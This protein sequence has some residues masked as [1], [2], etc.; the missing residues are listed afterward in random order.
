[1]NRWIGGARNVIR[2]EKNLLARTEIQVPGVSEVI[3]GRV[4]Q[5]LSLLE[6]R[7][8]K[9]Y[10]EVLG[11]CQEELIRKKSLHDALKIRALL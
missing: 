6:L 7:K 3:M 8:K 4:N 1:M 9:E 2:K 11:E 5:L 10:F